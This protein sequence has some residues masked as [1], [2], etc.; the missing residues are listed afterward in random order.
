M[1]QAASW[2]AALARTQREIAK[3][4]LNSQTLLGALR[5]LCE[6]SES[7]VG[8]IELAP[9]GQENGC[10]GTL[11]LH[12]AV[13]DSPVGQ[14][15]RAA[16]TEALRSSDRVVGPT[17]GIA[18]RGPDDEVEG[19][20][21]LTGRDQG[22]DDEVQAVVAAVADALGVSIRAAR[23]GSSGA[24]VKA[25]CAQRMLNE[26]PS[27]VYVYDLESGQ[28]C[29]ANRSA[30]EMLTRESGDLPLSRIESQSQIHPDDVSRLKAHLERMRAVA[31]DVCVD[32]EYRLRTPD[33]D[34][35]WV[36]SRDRVLTRDATGRARQLIGSSLDITH[37]KRLEQELACS[38]RRYRTLVEMCPDGIAVFREGKIAFA[39]PAA[40]ELVGVASADQMIGLTL[41]DYLHP[42][43]LAASQERQ[44][45][46]V[47]GQKYPLHEMRMRRADGSYLPVETCAAPC[48]FEGGPAILVVGRRAAQRTFEDEAV[49]KSDAFRESL[50]RTVAEGICVCFPIPHF[51]KLLFTV[52]NDRM[53]E[54]TGYTMEEINRR[55]WRQ[56]LFR[57]PSGNG[58]AAQ[59]MTRLEH[60]GAIAE[61][62][63]AITRADGAARVLAVST[64]R[65]ASDDLSQGVVMAVHDVTERNRFE[66]ELRRSEARYRTFAD[67][68]SDGLFLTN[69]QG[70]VVDVNQRA[71][72]RLGYTREE[73]IGRSPLDFNPETT[74]EQMQARLARLAAGEAMT[75]ES[76]H[77]RRDGSTF[78]VELR[79]CPFRVGDD[80]FT[81]ALACDITDRKR[82]EKQLRASELRF[83]EFMRHLPGLAWIK[84]LEGRYV[85]GN[86]SFCQIV[87][88]PLPELLGKVDQ[89]LVAAEYA[90]QFRENDRL[91]LAQGGGLQTVETLMHDDGVVHH[92]LVSKFP[93]PGADGEPAF[94]GGVA[95]DITDRQ[96]AEQALRESEQRLRTLLENLEHVAVQ[97]YEPDGTI[98]FW[99]QGSERL[100]GYSAAEALG[101]D[102]VTL[103]QEPPAHQEERRVMA[104]ALRAGGATPVGEL[105]ATR[106]DGERIWIVCSR[107]VH[108]RAGRAPEFFCFD[109]D[110]T[111]KKRAQE[112]L[113]A[114]QSELLHAAR[115]STVGEM[116]AALSH[117]VAQPLTSIVNFA[118]AAL[119]GAGAW[120][121]RSA[122]TI[123]GYLTSIEQQSQRCRAILQR[124][125]NF[126]R[127]ATPQRRSCALNDIL[128]D[129]LELV[130]T[131]L[132]RRGIALMIDLC[133]DAPRVEVEPIELEQVVVNLLTNARDALDLAEQTEKQITLRSMKSASG[134]IFE[135][136]DNGPGLDPQTI[137][138]LFEPFYTTKEQGMG[139]GLVICQSIVRS[140]GGTIEAFNNTEGGVTFR[141]WLP[142]GAKDA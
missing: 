49:R 7:P 6:L 1:K 50:I 124:L 87:G 84:D 110:V 91:A 8:S 112:E 129:S 82:A 136:A 108:P 75:L 56:L 76:V 63:W 26:S 18:L 57:D 140:Q 114:R 42:D 116:V 131:D 88:R 123:K 98:T 33:G 105:E 142:Q 89:E 39:N 55:G 34:Y 54:L 13:S 2:V 15:L 32:V 141:V 12:G 52:W 67:N 4:G 126:S 95:F 85:Y 96:Q 35:R 90:V 65:I 24:S 60:G 44:S 66:E 125:R 130:R 19:V 28:P 109:V 70:L 53:R 94:V 69:S 73:L 37:L 9:S 20:A 10:R 43:E 83:S 106:R 38:E 40:L 132:R 80:W 77:L 74:F 46:V 27:S 30:M 72:E 102:V 29:F 41:N 93:I 36:L 101:R 107:I 17:L 62:Q 138:R 139:I 81:L 61:E 11:H 21:A 3:Q 92:S 118:A 23:V 137:P 68:I 47:G 14:A 48:E 58:S 97:A 104:E 117:E 115:L 119:A 122:A 31:D 135:V 133:D 128:T 25:E 22:Y 134:S 113:A 111:D 103:L 100:Y 16:S 79:L 71:C 45:R 64:S 51:P 59:A 86:R 127:R 78:P 121:E 5:L 99:N 120:D